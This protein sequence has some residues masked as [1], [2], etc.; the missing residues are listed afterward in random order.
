VAGN[1]IKMDE[2]VEDRPPPRSAPDVDE[3]RESI[4]TSLGASLGR[5]R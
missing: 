3:D 4:L 2:S 5:R 1:P